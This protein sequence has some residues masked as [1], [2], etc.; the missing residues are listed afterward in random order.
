MALNLLDLLTGTQK[1]CFTTIYVPNE[2]VG[3]IDPFF[4][5]NFF[6]ELASDWEI[7][8]IQGQKHI[9]HFNGLANKPLLTTGWNTLGNHYS[10]P[11]IKILHFFYYGDKTFYMEI[12]NNAALDIPRFFPQFHTLGHLI[13]TNQKFRIQVHNKDI[14]ASSMIISQQMDIFITATGHSQVKLSGPL[15]NVVTVNLIRHAGNG[16]RVMFG[17]GWSTFCQLNQLSGGN[18]LNFKTSAEFDYS[19]IFLIEVV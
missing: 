11:A 18:L 17:E 4:V 6:T 10:W 15:N 12:N 3:E 13:E 1:G 8:D 14:S 2:I 5:A 19:N 7:I 9:V 16:R